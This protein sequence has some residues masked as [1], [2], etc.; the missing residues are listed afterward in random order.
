MEME[1]VVG[2]GCSR[3]A[4]D[5]HISI[6]RQDGKGWRRVC[7]FPKGLCDSH[8][9][10][11]NQTGPE[12]HAST[13]I[14]PFLPM[15]NRHEHSSLLRM[16]MPPGLA[17]AAAAAAASRAAGKQGAQGAGDGHHMVLG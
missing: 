2:Q 14:F 17:K 3:W 12:T 6:N 5:A 1:G 13:S 11:A 4:R 16:L 10:Y 15:F 7:Y 8:P 9:V